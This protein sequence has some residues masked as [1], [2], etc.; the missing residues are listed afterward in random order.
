MKRGRVLLWN[1]NHYYITVY[2]AL[3]KSKA[4]LPMDFGSR[5]ALQKDLGVQTTFSELPPRGAAPQQGAN[6][7]RHAVQLIEAPLGRL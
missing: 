4:S 7:V 3:H 5:F 2:D 1:G 6:L